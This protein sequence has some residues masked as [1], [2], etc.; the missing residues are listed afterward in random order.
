MEDEGNKFSQKQ[1]QEYRERK[2]SSAESDSENEALHT[3]VLFLRE[4]E[5]KPVTR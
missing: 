1:F 2:D 5:R 3:S 4:V